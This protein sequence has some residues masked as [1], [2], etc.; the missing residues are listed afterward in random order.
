MRASAG[1]C[2]PARE[3]HRAAHLAPDRLN[4]AELAVVQRDENDA[5]RLRFYTFDD[6]TWE[7]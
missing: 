2:L 6:S 4:V 3:P 7:P 1:A 5:P